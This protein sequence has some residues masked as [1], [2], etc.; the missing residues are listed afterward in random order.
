ML[1][2]RAALWQEYR[3]LYDVEVAFAR[4]AA[5]ATHE[6]ANG[7]SQ[8]MTKDLAAVYQFLDRFVQIRESALRVGCLDCGVGQ[9]RQ[10][11]GEQ[12]RGESARFQTYE[13]TFSRVD[14]PAVGGPTVRTLGFVAHGMRKGRFSYYL[15]SF[16]ALAG[17]ARESA[18]FS[19]DQLDRNRFRG[20]CLGVNHRLLAK[21][22]PKNCQ[23]WLDAA[24][25]K[26]LQ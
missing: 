3:R 18:G 4:H 21:G 5:L 9:W 11:I 8:P 16:V 13:R 20:I 10:R 7:S 2:A 12:G 24:T 25:R 15:T 17:L 6:R 19:R 23:L 1:R 26:A 14:A 22:E